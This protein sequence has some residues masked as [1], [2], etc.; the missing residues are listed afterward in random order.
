MNKILFSFSELEE[1]LSLAAKLAAQKGRWTSA[2]RLAFALSLLYEVIPGSSA[3]MSRCDQM[4]LHCV[5][6]YNMCAQQTV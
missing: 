1:E 6:G 4:L 3:R 2:M 5:R